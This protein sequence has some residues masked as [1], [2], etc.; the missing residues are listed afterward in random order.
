M[1]TITIH[2]ILRC[3]DLN[4]TSTDRNK[5]KIE[6]VM[7]QVRAT[8][9]Q[10]IGITATLTAVLPPEYDSCLLKRRMEFTSKVHRPAPTIICPRWGVH[11][12]SSLVLHVRL[13]Q[14]HHNCHDR[15]GCDQCPN[16]DNTAGGIY[17]E[18]EEERV[19]GEGRW[20]GDDDCG[21]GCKDQERLMGVTLCIWRR[22][23]RLVCIPSSHH[24]HTKSHERHGVTCSLATEWNNRASAAWAT[25]SQILICLRVRCF[26]LM[27]VAEPSS[28]IR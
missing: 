11:A 24:K 3:G 2:G 19:V 13:S 12:S 1:S 27:P 18:N 8:A 26:A 4:I 23:L 10:D 9:Y 7:Q 5:G 17:D 22:S 21:D 20:F 16:D 14:D 6:R 28:T 25:G 15:N